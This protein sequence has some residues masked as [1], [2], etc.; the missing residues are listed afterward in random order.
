VIPQAERGQYDLIG[1]V[2]AMCATC[3]IRH[4]KERRPV[5]PTIWLS[6]HVYPSRAPICPRWKLR[7]MR[8][9]ADRSRPESRLPGS[10]LC[11]ALLRTPPV[12]ACR[13]AGPPG[14]DQPNVETTRNLILARQSREVLM[15]SQSQTSNSKHDLE[16]CGIPDPEGGRWQRAL[17]VLRQHR[18]T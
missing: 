17:A 5:R 1:S 7:K 6:V 15:I 2:A 12:V 10:P 14:I 3:A 4:V 13:P 9:F 16:A 18:R 8:R 11:S